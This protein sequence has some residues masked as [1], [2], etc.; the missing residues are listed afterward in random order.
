MRRSCLPTAIDRHRWR[1]RSTPAAPS[2]CRSRTVTN[3]SGVLLAV[4]PGRS[5]P[6]GR[7]ELELLGDIAELG[8]LALFSARL[9]RNAMRGQG[10]LEAVLARMSQMREHERI[11]F[12]AMVQD[13]ILQSMVGAL[14]AMEGLRDA[15]AKPALEDFDHVVRMLSISV[16]DAR[17]VIWEARPAPAPSRACRHVIR[18]GR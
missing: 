11:S 10:R 3:S 4:T 7:D 1:R 6:Y 5:E 17:E 16:E 12:A 15:V 2:P 14:C 18:R 9:Y 8:S 13:D